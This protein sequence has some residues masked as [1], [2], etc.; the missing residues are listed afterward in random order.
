MGTGWANTEFRSYNFSSSHPEEAHLV[1]T[2]ESSRRRKGDDK[3][4]DHNEATQLKRTKTNEMNDFELRQ[5]L[6]NQRQM[7]MARQEAMGGK[8]NGVNQ[9]QT[10]V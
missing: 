3:P 1:E 8:A 5:H 9:M 10:K 2:I 6:E 4:L 7:E